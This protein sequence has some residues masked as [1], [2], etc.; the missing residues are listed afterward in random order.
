MQN[1]Q[2]SFG[3]KIPITNCQVKDKKN[4]KF[5]PATIY[6]ADCK[7]FS[8]IQEVDNLDG[9]W[10]FKSSIVSYMKI[11]YSRQLISTTD[12]ND[13]FYLLQTQDGTTLGL[14]QTNKEGSSTKVEFLENRRDKK[15][16]YVGQS[17][18]AAIGLET[19]KE[20]KKSI[21]ITVPT[22]EAIPFYVDKCGFKESNNSTPLKLSKK[23]I[24]KL[25]RK[26]ENKTN[27]NLIN[28]RA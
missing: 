1:F 4:G 19:L 18:L 21:V 5:V 14:C 24:K 28:L 16:K 27:T 3:K 15:Y 6:E 12:K 13:K 2:I 9:I 22:E 7:D 8:D 20:G 17:L 23:R 11:K 26:T 25:I 10:S